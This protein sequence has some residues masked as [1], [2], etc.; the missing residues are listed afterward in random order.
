MSSIKQ[1]DDNFEVLEMTQLI[2]M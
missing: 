1:G 2:V